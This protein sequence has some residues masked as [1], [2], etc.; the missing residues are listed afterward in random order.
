LN[1]RLN[2]KNSEVSKSRRLH[3]QDVS[4]QDLKFPL[5]P[6]PVLLIG[7][8]RPE[9]IIRRVKE[10]LRNNVKILHISIDGCDSLRETMKET[11]E[12]VSSLCKNK[13]EVTYKIHEKNIGLARHITNEITTLI[14]IHS[15]IIVLEDDIQI[16][17]NFLVNM[18][19]G[20][21]CL[22]VSETIGIVSAFS[23]INQIK[24]FKLPNKW[25][26]TPYFSCW[27]WLCTREVWEK[28]VLDISEIKVN[29][30]LSNSITWQEL[31]KWQQFLWLSRFLKIQRNPYHTWDI[32]FQ[33]MCFRYGITNIAPVFSLTNNEGFNDTRSAHTKEKKPRWMSSLTIESTLIRNTISPAASVLFSKFIE[34][35]TTSGDSRLIRLR[36]SVK[37]GI[38]L[39]KFTKSSS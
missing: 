21:D 23:P 24:Y 32:Q 25:R 9:L 10:L 12:I 16:G 19:R 5:L 37:K 35:L 34:P 15:E 6:I 14:T 2:I 33:F 39:K 8:N 28:Y 13:C 38:E 29:E 18:G 36:N 4:Q 26:E 22:K 7:Y 3:Y 1:K 11:L 30:A 17:E 31:N 27:G 20:L